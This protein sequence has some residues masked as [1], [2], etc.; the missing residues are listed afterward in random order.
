LFYGS[1]DW[2]YAYGNS[3]PEQILHDADL[4]A[5]IRSSGAAPPFTVIDEGWEDRFRFP[6][7]P[8][9]AQEIRKREVRPGIWGRLLRAPDTTPEGLLLPAARFGERRQ[10]AFELAYD[11]TVPEAREEICRRLREI[12]AWKFD[13]IKHDYSTYDM[14][15]QWGFELGAEPTHSGWSFHDQTRTNAEII[16]DF[17]RVI[18]S[19]VGEQVIVLGC[20]T[21]GHLAA[22]IFDIQ[23]IGDD[24]SGK[25]WE[26]TRRMGVN[27]LANRL[28][29]HKTFFAADPDCVPIT[30]NIPWDKTTQWLELVAASG[31][32]LFISAV[33]AAVGPEQKRA[34]SRAF[35]LA[36]SKEATAQPV[37]WFDS[38][39]P[40]KWKFQNGSDSIDHREEVRFKWC[41]SDGAFPFRI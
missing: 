33:R 38:T 27:S 11:P 21:V 1:N 40:E 2:Y 29:Q 26:R 14:L 34:L 30:E 6:D 24:T 41:G 12:V 17:Y 4:V 39:T 9:L 16:L 36:T 18:R 28:A 7:M 22:G 10:R 31:T 20:N 3:S 19:T 15:G 25:V 8:G 35:E 32:P 37:N 13:L 23:R 5:S